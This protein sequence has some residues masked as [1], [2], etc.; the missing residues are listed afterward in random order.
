MANKALIDAMGEYYKAR[1]GDATKAVAEGIA[2][3][4]TVAGLYFGHQRK[5]ANERLKDFDVSQIPAALQLWSPSAT[6]FWSGELDIMNKEM[7]RLKRRPKKNITEIMQLDKEYERIKTIINKMP[8]FFTEAKANSGDGEQKSGEY[9]LASSDQYVNQIIN[10]QYGL[11]KNVNGEY[12]IKLYT[13]TEDGRLTDYEGTIEEFDDQI[14]LKRSDLGDKIVGIID[15][16]IKKDVYEDGELRQT[17]TDVIKNKQNLLSAFHDDIFQLTSG[18]FNST[19]LAHQFASEN[20][21][22]ET[23]MKEY[24]PHSAEFRNLTPEL[25]TERINEMREYVY[26]KVNVLSQYRFENNKAAEIAKSQRSKS[27]SSKQPLGSVLGIQK[28][29]D[30]STPVKL[31]GGEYSVLPRRINVTLDKI[32]AQEE[33]QV[34]QGWNGEYYMFHDGKWLIGESISGKRTKKKNRILNEELS[35]GDIVF[36]KKGNIIEET[37]TDRILQDLKLYELRGSASGS[38]NLDNIGVE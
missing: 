12:M 30:L 9:S 31:G 24:L 38:V 8:S 16:I 29:K 23:K 37:S 2:G 34:I 5:K 6:K 10:E 18:P 35:S 21:F 36:T 32:A 27:G 33:G 1:A 19:T 28:F 17:L 13:D 11:Y 25:Q 4:A 20:G 7:N 15:N 22:D 26:Q 14:F 3:I